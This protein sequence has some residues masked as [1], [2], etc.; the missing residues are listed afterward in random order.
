MSVRASLNRSSNWMGQLLSMAESA[1]LEE[2]ILW[3]A[4]TWSK[5][6]RT[7]GMLLLF[8]WVLTCSCNCKFWAS[9][10]QYAQFVDRHA[11]HCRK[12][13]DFELQTFFGELNCILLLELPSAPRLNLDK[14]TTV[15]LALIREVKATVRESIYYYKEFGTE[16]VVDLE[17]VQCVIRRVKDRGEWAIVDRSDNM[18]IQWYY[19]K[20]FVVISRQITDLPYSQWMTTYNLLQPNCRALYSVSSLFHHPPWTLT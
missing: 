5:R 7:A 16:E 9:C 20:S 2:A 4:I 19:C 10:L 17:T 8:E 13:P 12:T 3:S 11:H 15:I 14:P 6:L 1:A 18:V